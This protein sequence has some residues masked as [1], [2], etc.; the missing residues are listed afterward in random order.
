MVRRVNAI[1]SE[2][3]LD[4]SSSTNVLLESGMVVSGGE[5]VSTFP[6]T[7]FTR[8]DW[9]A[10][11]PALILIGPLPVP[12]GSAAAV[13]WVEVAETTVPTKGCWPVPST[14]PCVFSKT[15]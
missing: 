11:V 4:P 8:E 6:F 15:T 14:N 2:M 9:P 7:A 5:M 3:P 10:P 13:I 1:V 12:A